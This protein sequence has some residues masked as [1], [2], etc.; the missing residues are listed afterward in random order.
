MKPFI[1]KLAL[2]SFLIALADY[3]WN[4]YMPS[5]YFIPKIWFILGF[6]VAVTI[7]FHFFTMVAAKGKPQ[8]FIRFYMGS[9]ALRMALCLIVIIVYRFIDKPTVIPFVLAFMVHYFLFTI[10]EVAAVLRFLRK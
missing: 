7:I 3:C 10:F 8:N 9:T 4:N 1:I 6:F 2:Y 5:A